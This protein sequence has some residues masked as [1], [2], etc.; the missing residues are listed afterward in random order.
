LSFIAGDYTSAGDWTERIK[1]TKEETKIYEIKYIGAQNLTPYR[2][3]NFALAI[4][5]YVYKISTQ[6]KIIGKDFIYAELSK[7]RK[8]SNDVLFDQY[9][10]D[11]YANLGL[12]LKFTINDTQDYKTSDGKEIKD[13]QL[14]TQNNIDPEKRLYVGGTVEDIL[15]SLSTFLGTYKIKKDTSFETL[16]GCNP[17]NQIV[18]F[19]KLSKSKRNVQKEYT[20]K[21]YKY[22]SELVN[23]VR[24]AGHEFSLKNNTTNSVLVLQL[25]NQFYTLPKNDILVVFNNEFGFDDSKNL[26]NILK[27]IK[28]CRY[29]VWLLVDD[30]KND[31]IKKLRGVEAPLD[32]IDNYLVYKYNASEL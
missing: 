13:I 11:V 20:T 2:D 9:L 19:W 23:N 27:K 24:P 6:E 3:Y 21:I 5:A 16:Q 29:K 22:P 18:E 31:S 10:I 14:F 25:E 12:S 30:E 15:K 26:K 32:D 7:S 4:L 8:K 28:K 1:N 17:K